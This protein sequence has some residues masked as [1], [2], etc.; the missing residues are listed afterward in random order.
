MFIILIDFGLFVNFVNPPFFIV[1]WQRLVHRD[2]L[3]NVAL[4][5]Q[6]LKTSSLHFQMS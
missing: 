1:C 2:R 6:T 3:D 4:H 5:W